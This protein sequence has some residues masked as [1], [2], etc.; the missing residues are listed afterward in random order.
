MTNLPPLPTPWLRY[1]RFTPPRPGLYKVRWP[2]QSRHCQ[3]HWDG[4]QWQ[5]RQG[6]QWAPCSIRNLQCE[7]R[8]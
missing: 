3:C 1:P 2:E 5:V 4:H 8:A 6:E 7:W